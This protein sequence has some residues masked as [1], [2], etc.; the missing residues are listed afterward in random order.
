MSCK[1]TDRKTREFKKK[2]WRVA[3]R[4]ISCSAFDG[5]RIRHSY[6]SDATCL[7]CGGYWRTR[8]AYVFYLKNEEEK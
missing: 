1:C 5:Y 3:R 4:N 6:Y 7:L 8:A 2:N